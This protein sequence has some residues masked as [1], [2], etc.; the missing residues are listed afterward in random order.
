MTVEMTREEALALAF[1]ASRVY[2][3]RLTAHEFRGAPA[4]V[5]EH[6]GYR[7]GWYS[8]GSYSF[9]HSDFEAAGLEAR[10]V[11]YSA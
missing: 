8:V 1:A 4:P 6:F 2:Q 9:C 3:E 10:A 5:A 11:F 7:H